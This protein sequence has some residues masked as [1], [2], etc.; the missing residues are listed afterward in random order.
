MSV[1]EPLAALVGRW[2]GT[3]RL[4]MSPA[5]PAQQSDSTATVSL[6][7]RGRFLSLEYTWSE[8]G[9]PQAGQILIGHEPRS[10]AVTAV[11]IDSW[12]M[13]DKMMICQGSLGP[14][15]AVTLRGAYAAPPGP[16]WGWQIRLAPT[17]RGTFEIV[18]YNVTPE[19]K[20]QVAV[21]VG[22]SR[23]V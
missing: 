1:P 5:E 7:A 11:W 21:E 13:G 20:A 6:A 15:G 14:D 19:G 2:T 17:P 9:V 18:M 23:Q 10:G 22:Y 3:M 12:H 8:E 4:W 16:D